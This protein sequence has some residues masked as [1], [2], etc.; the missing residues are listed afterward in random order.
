MSLYPFIYMKISVDKRCFIMYNTCIDNEKREAAWT[1]EN[2]HHMRT[3]HPCAAAVPPPCPP[4]APMCVFDPVEVR[5]LVTKM[6]C[7]SAAGPS[8]WTLELLL[9]LLDDEACLAGLSLLCQ[10]IA[11][12]QLDTHSRTLLTCSILHAIPKRN[13]SLRP[14][15]LGELH[16][17]CYQVLLLPRR[18]RVPRDLRTRADGCW[19]LAA[20]S[21]QSSPCKRRWSATLT[22]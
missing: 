7:Y 4:S 22:T 11:S 14:L 21:A 1:P 12:D 10:L 5:K 15:A 9:P 19:L 17:N 2:L 16:Q 8:G 13:G 20:L 18:A 6:A 3:L